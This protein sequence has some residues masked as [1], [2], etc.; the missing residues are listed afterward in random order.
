MPMDKFIRFERNCV[1]H[2]GVAMLEQQAAG[3]ISAGNIAVFSGPTTTDSLDRHSFLAAQNVVRRLRQGYT[4]VEIG[5]EVG[6][7]LVPHLLDPTCQRVVSI[8]LRPDYQPDERGSQFSYVGHSTARMIETLRPLMPATSLA[9]LATFDADARQVSP[10]AI[11]GPADLVLIDGEHT[12]TAAFSDFMSLLPALSPNAVVLFHDANLVVDAIANIERLL[13]YECVPFTTYF[14]P[15]V[16]AA[17]ALRGSQVT[18]GKTFGPIAL[19]RGQFV[20]LSKRRL[21]EDI[22]QAVAINAHH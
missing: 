8:D 4:Y 22:A 2:L 1:Y 16:V 13:Q 12:V 21:R 18:A 3:L 7:T 19:D 14:L 6:G 5:S 20:S 9:K 11:A 10:A 15:S 17:I